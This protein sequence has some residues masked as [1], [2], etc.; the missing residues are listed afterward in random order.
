MTKP[1]ESVKITK[2]AL[3]IK[4]IEM[5][6]IWVQG[7]VFISVPSRKLINRLRLTCY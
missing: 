3:K 7:T 2:M 1:C 6:Q 5:N 4:D